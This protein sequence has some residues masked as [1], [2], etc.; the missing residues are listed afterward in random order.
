MTFFDWLASPLGV[1]F[2]HALIG[3]ILALAAYLSYLA[4]RQAKSNEELLNGHLEQHMLNDVLVAQPGRRGTP[5]E[6]P[7]SDRP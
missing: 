5:E 1:E 4:H 7:A 3:L 6:P 2:Q